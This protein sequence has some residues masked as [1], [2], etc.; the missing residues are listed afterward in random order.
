MA[1]RIM[2]RT[3]G[4]TLNPQTLIDRTKYEEL[5]T[6]ACEEEVRK[7]K[8]SGEIN[9]KDGVSLSHRWH[10]TTLSITSANGTTSVDLRGEK[11][12]QGVAGEQGPKGDP[13]KD[14]EGA[15]RVTYD[16]TTMKASHTST[17]ILAA[18]E[19]GRLVYFVAGT[20]FAY[21]QFCNHVIARFTRIEIYTV[22]DKSLTLEETYTVGQDYT[23]SKSEKIIKVENF[24]KTVNGIAP[25]EDGNVVLEIEEGVKTVNGVSPDKN[26]N[27]QIEVGGSGGGVT[28]WNDLEDRPIYTDVGLVEILPETEFVA[29]SNGAFGITENVPVLE[30]GN[31]YAVN[32][33][34]L[35]Y[36][37]VCENT[38]ANE[39]GV[40]LGN[41]KILGG[42]DTG[43]PFLL[44][45]G[46]YNGSQLMVV[47]PGDN[48]TSVTI[49]INS[50]SEVQYFDPKYIKDMYYTEVGMVE[51]LP[52]TETVFDDDIG[53][54][55]V[56]SNPNLEIG[57]SYTLNYNGT[58]YTCVA[59]DISFMGGDGSV[60]LGNLDML[61]ES[62]DT[63][64]PFFFGSV[65][66]S[67]ASMLVPF[68]GATSVTISIMGG[69]EVIHHLDEKY[70]PE[71]VATKEWVNELLGGIE[72]GAY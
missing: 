36:V 10:G 15:L 71:S 27:V 48:P 62:G 35:E 54:F 52:E 17:E 37:C 6:S 67:G 29:D 42:Q 59:Q 47:Y 58:E 46:E 3:V 40:Y 55:L 65:P 45:Y 11:G 56:S 18:N 50:K 25:D 63:G 21:L 32:Y 12:D 53:G 31:T 24:V 72:N 44:A 4:T 69:S 8:E 51:I 49:S 34:G 23:V 1:K 68:D 38:G 16:T 61:Q 43:E 22:E 64:E 41:A 19:A 28:S 33:N 7:L 70:L 14:A 13:G 66:E 20:D 60:G 2:G 30:L 9:G 26:G 39:V 5:I 57:K